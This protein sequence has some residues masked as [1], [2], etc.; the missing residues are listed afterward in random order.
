MNLSSTTTDNITEVLIKIIEFTERRQQLLTRN[1]RD[2]NVPRFV[3]QDLDTAEFADLMAQALAEHIRNQRLLLR[4]SKNIKFGTDGNFESL[5][6][7]DEHARALLEED[8]QDYID[9]Q[10]KKL[11]ENL[12]NNKVAYRLLRQKQ[13]RI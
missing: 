9:L 1:I 7:I 12:L 6:I 13:S 4:D 3:P 5:P 8:V 10:I 11:S 2:I